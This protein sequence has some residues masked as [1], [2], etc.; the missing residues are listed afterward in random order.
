MSQRYVYG[1][2]PINRDTDYSGET[3]YD[4]IL[5]DTPTEDHVYTGLL[6]VNGDHIVRNINRPHFGFI[7][8]EG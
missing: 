1:I 3:A 4:I 6:D 2:K 5:P 7:K 8:L